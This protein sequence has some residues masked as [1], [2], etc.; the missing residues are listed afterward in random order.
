MSEHTS[1]DV[2]Q[3]VLD[4]HDDEGREVVIALVGSAA[5]VAIIL[6]VFAF[7]LQLR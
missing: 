5:L 1:S 7:T 4:H 2:E 6:L 3:D